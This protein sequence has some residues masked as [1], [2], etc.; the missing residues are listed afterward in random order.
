MGSSE[1]MGTCH[2]ASCGYTAPIEGT[3]VPVLG[4][5]EPRYYTRPYREPS[6]EQEVIIYKR[7]GLPPGTVTGY[8]DIDD[9]FILSVDGPQHQRRGCIAYSLSGAKPK[10]LTYKEKLEQPF[11]HWTMRFNPP[12]IVL[13]EDWFSAEKVAEAGAT[14]VALLGTNLNQEAVNEIKAVAA[15]WNVPTFVALD[16]DAYTKSLLYL[17]KYREQFPRGLYAW[18]LRVDLKYE[19]VDRIK[20]AL[21]GD[22]DFGSGNSRQGNT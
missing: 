14:G 2:R 9:R 21:D 3:F 18:S 8:N 17:S 6:A 19:T 12:A 5:R 13:V 1:L 7:F 16:R 15:N 4:K 22:Y 11:I 10:S 20:R